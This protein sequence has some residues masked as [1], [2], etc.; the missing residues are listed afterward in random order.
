MA[1]AYPAF[2]KPR[3]TP[4]ADF[5]LSKKLNL[6][7]NAFVAIDFWENGLYSFYTRH[8]RNPVF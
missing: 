2:A 7:A 5:V 4:S 6:F 3:P 8:E 1:K